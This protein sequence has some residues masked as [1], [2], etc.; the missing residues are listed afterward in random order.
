LAKLAK[1]S[2]VPS[3]NPNHAA[4][5]PKVARKAGM[6]AVAVSW[7]QSLNNEANPTPNTVRLSQR[8]SE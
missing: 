7:D 2:E 3:I 5:A 6:T 1:P 8:A 4:E